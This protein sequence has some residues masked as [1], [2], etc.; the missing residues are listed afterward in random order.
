MAAPNFIRRG[1]NLTTLPP[2]VS[3]GGGYQDTSFPKPPVDLGQGN[4]LLEALL[5]RS[6]LAAGGALGAGALVHPDLVQA[7]L[8][9]PRRRPAAPAAE[10]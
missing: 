3:Q 7:L 10:D 1:A 4:P 5:G 9:I 8:G 6:G 2:E